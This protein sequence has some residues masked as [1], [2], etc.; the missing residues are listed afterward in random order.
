[1][2]IDEKLLRTYHWAK[3][4]GFPHFNILR[5]KKSTLVFGHTYDKGNLVTIMAIYSDEG[6]CSLKKDFNIKA[7]GNK[8][9]EKKHC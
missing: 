3:T 4:G 2:L 9:N 8:G 6:K 7:T 5:K 1:M